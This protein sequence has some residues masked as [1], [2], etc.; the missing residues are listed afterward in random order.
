MS[1]SSTRRREVLNHDDPQ[2]SHE[3]LI[4]KGLVGLNDLM[5]NI[6]KTFTRI[7]KGLT[8]PEGLTDRQGDGR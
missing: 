3:E 6:T 1:K 4:A 5:T 2:P 8:D 7:P